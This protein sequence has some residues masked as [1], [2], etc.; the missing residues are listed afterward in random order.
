MELKPWQSS[1]A[2]LEMHLN[3]LCCDFPFVLGLND[4]T[5]STY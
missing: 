5:G 4:F 2:M 1:P 3:R